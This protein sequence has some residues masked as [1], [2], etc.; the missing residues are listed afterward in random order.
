MH[1]QIAAG[2][3]FSMAGIPYWSMDIGGFAVESKYHTKN[4]QLTE[5]WRE[6]QTRW[7]QFGAFVPLFRS[8]GQA[9]AREIFHI[10]PEGHPAYASMLYYDQ[11]RYRL[12]PYI[13]SMGAATYFKDYTPMRGLAMD[14]PRDPKAAAVTDAFMFGPAL[15]IEPVT[16]PHQTTK[17]VY[18][19]AAGPDTK[20][21]SL[22]DGRSFNSGQTIRAAAPYGRM[23][24]FVPSGTILPAGPVTQYT[25][26][27]ADTLNIYVYAGKDGQ[28][29]LYEDQGTSYDYEKGEYRKITF[30]YQDTAG[31]LSIDGSKG[32]YP[33]T[34][35]KTLRI[36][37]VRPEAPAGV[38]SAESPV[39]TVR[40]TGRP[41]QVSLR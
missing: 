8:H 9:P 1:R 38:D 41:V 3:S 22:Y 34:G 36:Y 39:K 17:T 28:F 23:P 31:R 33:G 6:L 24:V 27:L 7:Y 26:P 13:Y 25:G 30:H 20:W 2:I 29:T 5:D 15:L 40:Y 11:L 19:P 32:T 12:M 14:F 37:W 21:Y 35:D 18:L 16:A 4:P 10:A